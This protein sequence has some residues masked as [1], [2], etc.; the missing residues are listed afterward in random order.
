MLTLLG[1]IAVTVF[2]SYRCVQLSLRGVLQFDVLFKLGGEK[3][4]T[5]H[6]YLHVLLYI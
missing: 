5:Y 3:M 2:E 6:K 1:Y 4:D